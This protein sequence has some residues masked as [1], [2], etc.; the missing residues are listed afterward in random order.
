MDMFRLGHNTVEDADLNDVAD[1][2]YMRI[3]V[4]GPACIL[5]PLISLSW[6]KPKRVHRL[7]WTDKI[8][9]HLWRS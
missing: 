6:N 8:L 5:N 9:L 2:M 1:V 3:H 7:M 4:S